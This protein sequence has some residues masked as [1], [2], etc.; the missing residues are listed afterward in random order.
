MGLFGKAKTKVMPIP[1]GFSPENIRVEASVCTGER[2]IGFYSSEDRRL[3]FAE[4]VRSPED[5]RAFYEKYGLKA[6]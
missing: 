4:L 5:I 2:T 6:E 1:E 3:H